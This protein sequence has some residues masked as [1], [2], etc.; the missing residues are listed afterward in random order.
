M[1]SE[2]ASFLLKYQQFKVQ[3]YLNT[4]IIN[5]KKRLDVVDLSSN[6][7]INC[8]IITTIYAKFLVNICLN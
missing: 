7:L 6:V 4:I 8:F 2:S 3:M 5:K 1:V